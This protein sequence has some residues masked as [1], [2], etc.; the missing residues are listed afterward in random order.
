[1]Q[2]SVLASLGEFEVNIG[3]TLTA[4]GGAKRTYSMPRTAFS[5]LATGQ[6]PD[7]WRLPSWADL[8]S[9]FVSNAKTN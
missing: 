2:S 5:S 3:M 7:V 4:I 1:M 6:C 9:S 8:G